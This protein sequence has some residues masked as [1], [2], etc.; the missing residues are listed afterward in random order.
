MDSNEIW[1]IYGTMRP[2][3]MRTLQ[4]TVSGHRSLMSQIGLFSAPL[5]LLH[6]PCKMCWLPF[7]L[8]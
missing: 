8:L 2:D 7:F 5:F 6:V 1:G 4:F 3:M